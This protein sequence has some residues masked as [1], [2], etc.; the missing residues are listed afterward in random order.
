MPGGIDTATGVT[1][2]TQ[3]AALK[4]FYLPAI[5]V[6]FNSNVILLQRIRKSSEVIEGRQVVMSL[7][8]GRNE[9]FAGVEQS[10]QLPDP[11]RQGYT[12]MRFPYVRLYSRVKI[13]GDVIAATKSAAGAFVQAIESEIDGAVRDASNEVNRMLYHDGSG[14][15]GEVTAV[16]ADT[17]DVKPVFDNEQGTSAAERVKFIRPGM[18]IS[19]VDADAASNIF[20]IDDTTTNQRNWYVQSVDHANLMVTCDID[21]TSGTGADFAAGAAG[22]YVVRCRL[23]T[24][25]TTAANALTYSGYRGASG[26]AAN[27]QKEVMGLAGIVDNQNVHYDI[28]SGTHS[29]TSLQTVDATTVDLWQATKIQL[30][31]VLTELALQ[32]ALDTAE[33]VGNAAITAIY[34]DYRS[35]RQYENLGFA[36]KRFVNTVTYDGGYTTVTFNDKPLIADKDCSPGV[37]YFIDESAL[38]W[39][40]LSDWFW[41]DKDG[42]I[43]SRLDDS[44]QY[45]ATL[46]QYCE[47]VTTRRNAHALIHDITYS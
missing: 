18:W 10:G 21:E 31:D 35:R 11:G 14:R 34:C 37:Y 6:Q 42:A 1:L 30:N 24:A 7:A 32:Q 36:D 44:D 40:T 12:Q 27:P 23:R 20:V 2:T 17:F 26:A 9:S 19:I 25:L 38:M 33:E 43:L 47:F 22:D 45:Q 5:R 46:A 8:T 15:I 39:A 28:V 16:S 3:D 41:L 29:R 4:D 13:D